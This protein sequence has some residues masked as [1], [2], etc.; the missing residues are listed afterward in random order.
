[1][2]YPF[3]P[4]STTSLE[5]GHYWAVPLRSG[6]YA[7]GVV[8]AHAIRQEKRDSR[9]LCVGLLDWVGDAP[10]VSED[11]ASAPLVEYGFVHVRS[12]QRNGRDI[13]GHLER[14]FELARELDFDRLAGAG[15]SVWGLA[16]IHHRAELRWGDAAWVKAELARQWASLRRT[17]RTRT[18]EQRT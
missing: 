9:L 10:P 6:R 12:I 1:M 7:A 11:L 16:V 13:L 4:K 2:K 8:L 17:S 5:P 3:A 15:I 14:S 18:D